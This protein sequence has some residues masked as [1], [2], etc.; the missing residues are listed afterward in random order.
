MKI[1][2]LN[3]QINNTTK[4]MINDNILLKQI[5]KKSI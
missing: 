1:L 4:T 3:R 2:K 5:I